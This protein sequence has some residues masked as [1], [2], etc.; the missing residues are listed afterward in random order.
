MDKAISPTDPPQ[1]DASGGIIEE[2]PCLPGKGVSAREP[3]AQSIVL[4]SSS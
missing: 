1:Q 4:H 3:E 2:G